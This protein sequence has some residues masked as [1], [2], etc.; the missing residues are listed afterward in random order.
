[1]LICFLFIM[2]QWLKR[3]SL[4]KQSSTTAVST[5]AE[6]LVKLC[7]AEMA[8]CVLGEH[9]KKKLGTVQLHNNAVKYRIQDLSARME[10]QLVW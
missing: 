10:I 5:F 8:T 4:S 3:C 2:D 9:S 7:V 6:T 1:M